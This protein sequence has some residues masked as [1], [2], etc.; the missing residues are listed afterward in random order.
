MKK[1]SRLIM[2]VES[3]EEPLSLE[4]KMHLMIRE[5]SKSAQANW[6]WALV[7][8][9]IFAIVSISSINSSLLGVEINDEILSELQE[10]SDAVM[11]IAM[12]LFGIF[13]LI[14]I[15]DKISSKNEKK[16]YNELIDGFIRKSYLLNFET[17]IPKGTS[18]V[19][20][21]LNEALKVFPELKETKREAEKKDK[22]MHYELNKEFGDVTYD[23]SLK[24]KS[25][26][27]FLVKFVE[28]E[29]TFDE[30]QSVVKNTNKIFK[31]NLV[32]F[33]LLCVGK[34]FQQ[35]FQDYGI[36]ERM[37][38]L[39]RSFKLDLIDEYEKGYTMAWID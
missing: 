32:V 17:A 37:N 8:V 36:E 28:D 18:R 35:F 30:L 21:I 19:D 31:N 9:L 10:N 4:D 34:D 15:V 16:K 38:S 1:Q 27:F 12:V 11:Y 24:T 7:F 13:G 29:V 39:T 6:F 14:L 26:E 22:K 3:E 33:R 5:Q 20:K 23:L 25:G 2:S